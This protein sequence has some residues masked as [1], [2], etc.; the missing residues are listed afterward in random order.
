MSRIHITLV[1]GQPMPIFNGIRHAKPDKVVFI[2][3]SQSR[4]VVKRV[5]EF[6]DC[7]VVEQAPLDATEPTAILAKATGLYEQFQNDEISLN[8]SG[9]LK[10]WSHIFGVYFSGKPNASVFYIDQNNMVMD[11]GAMKSYPLECKSLSIVDYLKLYGNTLSTF[12]RFSDYS[13]EDIDAIARIKKARDFHPNGFKELTVNVSGEDKNTILRKEGQVS[14]LPGK[15]SWQYDISSGNTSLDIVLNRPNGTQQSFEIECP[16]ARHLVF[17]SGWFEIYVAEKLSRWMRSGEVLTNCVFKYDKG[18]AK[19]EVDI[20]INLGNK[21]LFVECKTQIF[22][23]TDLDK[24]IS[25]V[26]TM[27]GTATKA[28]FITE[29]KMRPETVTKCIENGIIHFSFAEGGENALFKL[30]DREYNKLNK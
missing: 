30:L 26:K 3:S 1:G 24:F 4:P 27:S 2:Y 12:S 29:S 13:E 23:N 8:I 21:L 19:N 16:H 6:I 10:S 14:K 9:G 17:N 5:K 28:I 15:I 22:N 18:Q 20:I 11:F 25:V 7:E